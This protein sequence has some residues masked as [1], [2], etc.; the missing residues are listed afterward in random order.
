MCARLEIVSH[1]CGRP[2]GR[3][4]HLCFV[5][6]TSCRTFYLVLLG[7]SFLGIG[8]KPP[9]NESVGQLASGGVRLS[10]EPGGAAGWSGSSLTVSAGLD[11]ILPSSARSITS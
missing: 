3:R 5:R 1:F 8:F 6:A 2:G 9:A 10:S 4:L 7:C 11:S